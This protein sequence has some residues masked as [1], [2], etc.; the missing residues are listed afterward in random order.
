M[1]NSSPT[2]DNP[3]ASLTRLS[4]RAILSGAGI[5]LLVTYLVGFIIQGY[6]VV[7]NG[8]SGASQDA[9]DQAFRA[10][11]IFWVSVV[12]GILISGLGGFVAGWLAREEYPL[13]GLIAAFL[14]NVVYLSIVSIGSPFTTVDFAGAMLGL[15]AG[16]GGGTLAGM[17]K[18]HRGP[19]T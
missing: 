17:L 18:M 1:K 12:L 15:L 7:S 13:H 5:D 19:Q 10:S 9:L 16:L 2:P 14:T 8:L 3:F 6:F 11:P 4:W